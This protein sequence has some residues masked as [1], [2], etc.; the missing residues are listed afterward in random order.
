MIKEP[1]RFDPNNP[2]IK[3]LILEGDI[4]ALFLA[5]PLLIILGI[6]LWI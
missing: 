1:N 2:I 5:L 6:W 3:R 4:F